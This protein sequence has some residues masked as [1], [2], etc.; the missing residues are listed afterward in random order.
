MRSRVAADVSR[1]HREQLAA[2][3]PAKRIALA[4]RLGAEGILAFMT[5]ARR[6][7]PYSSLR[8]H[9][10]R[11]R[12]GQV[13]VGGRLRVSRFARC[14]GSAR[15]WP[16]RDTGGRSGVA[17]RGGPTRHPRCLAG[18]VGA[19]P[20]TRRSQVP[21]CRHLVV[22]DPDA[23]TREPARFAGDARSTEMTRQPFAGIFHSHRGNFRSRP[24]DHDRWT[25]FRAR[26]PCFL[27]RLAV[28]TPCAWQPA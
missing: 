20:L 21:R 12:A 16:S 26:R 17:P 7:R 19:P 3:S 14:G 9:R 8:R 5:T 27:A 6:R 1:K 13:A 22:T 11:R 10:H 2:M 15:G 18:F 24:R 4:E 25:R 23:R 28:G